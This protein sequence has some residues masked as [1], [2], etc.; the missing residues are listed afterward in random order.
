MSLKSSKYIHPSIVK[1]TI[2]GLKQNS[3][4]GYKGAQII[5]YTIVNAHQLNTFSI[6]SLGQQDKS[7]ASQILKA[8]ELEIEPEVVEVTTYD[9]SQLL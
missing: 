1:L 3:L 2:Q 4:P 5:A 8:L 7:M 9:P 6:S